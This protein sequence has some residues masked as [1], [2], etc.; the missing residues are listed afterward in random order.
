MHIKKT[1]RKIEFHNQKHGAPIKIISCEVIGNGERY[2]Y[3]VKLKAGTKESLLFDRA[4]DIRTA[5]RLQ[6]YQPF[7]EG[8]AIRIAVSECPITEN[9]LK[10][11]LESPAFLK[12]KM[13]IP[14]ALGYDMRGEMRFVDLVKL[15]HAMYAGSTGSGKSV[16]LWC[17]ILSIIYL[18]TV[19][20]VNLLLFDVGANTLEPFIGIPHLSHPI[21]KDI[22][23]AIYVIKE[24]VVEM[25]KRM[26][27]AHSELL[28]KPAL[29]CI[30]DEYV[31]LISNIGDKKLSQ[32]LTGTI[33]NL[34]RRGRQVKIH[35][36]LATQDPTL[37][38]M[39]VDLGNITARMAFACAKYHN[40][41]TIL[42][43]GGAEK[44]PGRGAMLFKSNENPEPVYLQGAYMDT[45][46]IKRLVAYIKSKSYDFTNKFV[47][48]EIDLAQQQILPAEAFDP[49]TSVEDSQKELV[50][51]IFWVLGRD[52]VSK[53]QIMKQFHMGN[54]ADA[55]IDWLFKMNLIADKYAT[56]PRTVIPQTIEDIPT[57][58]TELLI[59]NGVSEDDIAGVIQNRS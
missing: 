27:L 39:K 26:K 2:I 24:L 48:P 29:V 23:T 12:S 4:K 8:L 46:E 11:M 42:G 37:K 30:I 25:E 13:K 35:M 1:A 44:L 49:K 50:D 57:E 58:I 31:S 22:T 53:L 7:K 40:S 16:G 9:S 43:E 18:Q 36:V 52:N 41:I 15:I 34:L 33:S 20:Q 59:N 28:K 47:I 38:N 19:S 6:L 54:R 17:L 56:Q 51:I 55:V 45:E 5:L 14:I 3:T 21:V 32:L 10:K